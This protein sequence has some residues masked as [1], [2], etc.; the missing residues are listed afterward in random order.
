MWRP[1]CLNEINNRRR[2]GKNIIYVDETYVQQSH[3]V[4]S[5]WQSEEEPGVLTKIGTD[6]RL[7]IVHGGGHEGFVEDALLIFKSGQKSGDYHSSMNSENFC[8]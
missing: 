3:S 7:I 6:Q 5:C 4:Q 2:E 1:R 8:K